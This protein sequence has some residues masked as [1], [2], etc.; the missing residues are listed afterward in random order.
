MNRIGIVIATLIFFTQ[1][2]SESFAQFGLFKKRK[3]GVIV[4]QSST[5]NRE[6][7][8]HSIVIQTNDPKHRCKRKSCDR[9]DHHIHIELTQ[10]QLLKIM[11]TQGGQQSLVRQP[12]Q[13]QS[14]GRFVAPPATGVVSR[15]VFVRGDSRCFNHASGIKASHAFN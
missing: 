15:E 8:T 14:A 1:L 2:T 11:K 4:R 3:K 10:E 5:Q 6:Q 12:T 9:S 7:T 13:M